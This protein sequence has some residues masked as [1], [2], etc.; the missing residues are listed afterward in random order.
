M[1]RR[2]NRKPLTDA[3]RDARRKADRERLEQ[4]AR[5]L[6]TTDGWQRWIKVRSSNGLSRYSV[7]NQMILA[8]EAYRRGITPTYVAGFRAWLQLNRVPRKGEGIRI[9]APISVTDRDEHGEQTDARRVFFKAVT[10]WDVAGTDPLPGKEPVRLA[11][12]AQPITGD[13]HHHLIAPL[14]AHAAELGYNVQLRDL[15]GHG[16]GG[17]C[18]A[19]RRQIVVA[20]GPAN[21]QVRTLTHE[22]AHAHGI[23]YQQYPRAQAEVLVD[24]VTYCVLGSVGLDVGGES[25]PYIA[26]WGEDGALDA[27]RGYAQ[28]IDTIARRIEDALD[29]RPNRPTLPSR[30]KPSP[31]ELTPVGRGLRR[32]DDRASPA[33][34]RPVRR[35]PTATPAGRSH[36]QRGSCS[37][38]PT[39]H[40]ADHAATKRSCTDAII[41]SSTVPSHAPYKGRESSSR[42]PARR[43]GRSSCAVS[44]SAMRSS[45]G[46]ASSRS[47]RRTDSPRSTDETRGSSG[48]A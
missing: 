2:F 42:T 48:C 35:S 29:A 3:Q 25:I 6:L 27:I 7:G 47:M 15:P 36:P 9:L 12:P 46:C 10:V 17:W 20:T 14:I 28:T 32:P 31:P 1:A 33:G 34:G 45:P 16:P 23:G 24:C 40:A 43:R 4:A 26:A 41:A 22:L 19:K 38:P 30:S 5:A 11:A 37:P 39:P 44:P 13:S 8:I 18:D 21:Q